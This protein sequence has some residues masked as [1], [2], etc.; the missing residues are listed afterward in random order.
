MIFE[1]QN[2]DFF[3]VKKYIL[4][5]FLWLQN[6]HVFDMHTKFGPKIWKLTYFE[7]FWKNLSKT[8]KKYLKIGTVFLTN[9]VKGPNFQDF[10]WKLR[11]LKIQGKISFS[12]KLLQ[13]FQE[14]C[15][16]Y[17]KWKNQVS[18]KWRKN[19]IFIFLVPPSKGGCGKKF[20]FK[21]A[22]QGFLI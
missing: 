11:A 6:W 9:F 12:V 14:N 4:G 1:H 22:D 7:R 3:Q 19:P 8:W 21:G 20:D 15:S 18:S 10:S 17:N 2:F 16:N 13:I 5:G